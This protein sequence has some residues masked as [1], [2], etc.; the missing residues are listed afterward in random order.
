MSGGIGFARDA[1]TSFER[2]RGLRS[3]KAPFQRAEENKFI[4]KNENTRT[5]TYESIS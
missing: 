1:Q 3:N 4:G 5:Y 2:N